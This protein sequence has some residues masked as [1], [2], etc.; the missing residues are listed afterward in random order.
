M[1]SLQI[2]LFAVAISFCAAGLIRLQRLRVE[3]PLRWLS[4]FVALAC[5][6]YSA[7]WLMLHPATPFKALWLW[8][9]M[10]AAL[11]MLPAYAMWGRS[12]LADVAINMRVVMSLAIVGT[13]LLVPLLLS[14]HGG[15]NFYNPDRPVSAQ[16]AFLIHCGMYACGSIF[17]CLAP[18]L[19][20][21]TWRAMG[22]SAVDRV[23]VKL[24]T[25]A[26]AIKW[27]T[28]FLRVLHCSIM[29]AHPGPELN[30]LMTLDIAVT[31]WVVS[32]VVRRLSRQ[33]TE[34]RSVPKAE[35]GKYASSGLNQVVAAR[36]LSKLEAASC[37][38]KLHRMPGLTLPALSKQLRESPHYVSQVLN[39]S[40]DCNYYD[41]INRQRIEDACEILLAQPEMTVLAVA[42]E[43]GFSAKST[44]NT[45][46]RKHTGMTPSGYRSASRPDQGFEP[47]GQGAV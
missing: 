47:N 20:L 19:M 10:S 26:M 9:V 18:L 34:T 21:A 46:F 39:E 43:V 7:E 28:C 4:A 5:L 35:D 25:L 45:A 1:N 27:L 2:S 36:I 42:E 13:L 8:A 22:A 37:Q 6:G 44:F 24:L 23:L 17:A 31:L 40:L 12:M 29:G 3:I 11:W 33:P 41:W 38:Q 16:Q 14:V 30:L 15:H 32:E